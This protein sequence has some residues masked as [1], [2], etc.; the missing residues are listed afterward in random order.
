MLFRS[1]VALENNQI[2]GAGSDAYLKPF[3]IAPA[4]AQANVVYRGNLTSAAEI[5]DP[6]LSR[7]GQDRQWRL[8]R[9]NIRRFVAGEQLLGVVDKQKGY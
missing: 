4:W 9:E 6:P 7:A 8:F 1:K 3:W 2:A 5:Q